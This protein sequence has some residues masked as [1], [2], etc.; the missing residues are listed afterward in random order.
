MI[1]TTSSTSSFLP[2]RKRKY[3]TSPT[4]LAKAVTAA[5][6]PC[7]IMQIY[8]FIYVMSNSENLCMLLSLLLILFILMKEQER[9]RIPTATTEKPGR[10]SER[11]IGSTNKIS[12]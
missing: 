3:H 12:E 6:D 10:M 11:D 1:F 4:K 7:I 5:D 9:E 8:F 2:S